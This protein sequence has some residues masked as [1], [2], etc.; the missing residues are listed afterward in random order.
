M[1]NAEFK[2]RNVY[3]MANPAKHGFGFVQFDKSAKFKNDADDYSYMAGDFKPL[4]KGSLYIVGKEQTN[5]PELK[6]VFVDEENT[7]ENL[8]GIDEVKAENQNSDAIYNLQGV[9]VNNAQ[10]G[11]Y[12]MNGKKVVIK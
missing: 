6:V 12:I 4:V 10:K 9:R 2:D 8:T 1:D 3:Y 5:A 7:D 11:I